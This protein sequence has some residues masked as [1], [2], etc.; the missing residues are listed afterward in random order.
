[1]KYAL[2]NEELFIRFLEAYKRFYILETGQ[3][4]DNVYWKNF[5]QWLNMNIRNPEC[6]FLLAVEGKKI[7]G[8]ILGYPLPALD[9]VKTIS[10]DPFY[11]FPEHRNKKI[12]LTLFQMFIGFCKR[13]GYQRI[14]GT[15]KFNENPKIIQWLRKKQTLGIQPKWLVV[16]KQ[17]EV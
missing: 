8:F 4:P 9:G 17:L 11:V 6:L 7:R 2:L 16:E 5:I 1:M 15:I 12:G 3:E 13:K 10:V 14:L